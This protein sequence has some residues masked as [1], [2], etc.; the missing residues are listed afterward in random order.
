MIV[1]CLPYGAGGR[2][3][4]PSAG[5]LLPRTASPG[6]VACGQQCWA[7]ARPVLPLAA[8]LAWAAIARRDSPVGGRRPRRSGQPPRRAVLVLPGL[9]RGG[10]R[11]VADLG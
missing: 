11:G 3:P 4:A 6:H 1:T 5:P 10:C 7:G 2:P 8:T 9:G